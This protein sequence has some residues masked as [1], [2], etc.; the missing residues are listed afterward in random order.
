MTYTE[1]DTFSHVY[2]EDSFVL[3]IVDGPGV[4][5]FRVEAVLTP[6]HPRYRPAPPGEQHCYADAWRTFSGVSEVRWIR[7]VDVVSYD[8]TGESDL[9]NIDY[10]RLADGRW[11]VGGDWGDVEVTGPPPTLRFDA[12]SQ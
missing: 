3:E 7:R 1:I 10:L 5:A 11:R 8:A 12:E 4:L 9:G 2:L 6:G